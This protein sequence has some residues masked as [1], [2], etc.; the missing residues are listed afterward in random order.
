VRLSAVIWESAAAI[1]GAGALLTVGLFPTVLSG[2]WRFAT[3]RSVEPTLEWFSEFDFSRYSTLPKLFSPEDFDFLRS[4]PGYQ[5]ELGSRLR[6]ERLKIAEGYLRELERDIRM[7][8]AL[9][10]R[11]CAHATSPEEDISG[12]LLKQ[13]IAFIFS[14]ARIR[15]QLSL[16]KAGLVKQVSFEAFLESLRPL[17]QQTRIAAFNY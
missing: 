10:T 4:Q 14:L 6:S 15:I 12:F 1:S 9:A 2:V 17:L 16:M 8:L 11:A 7:L 3:R 5:P 13:E